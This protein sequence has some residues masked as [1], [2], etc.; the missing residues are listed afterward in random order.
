MRAR[1][2]TYWCWANS[3]LH[4][5]C[6]AE[7]YVDGVSIDVEVRLS[8]EGLTQLFV[9]VYASEGMALLEEVYDTRLEETMT[10]ALAWGVVRARTTA[11]LCSLLV[12]RLWDP[13]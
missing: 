6:H 13:R 10:Q 4:S 9:G 12:C 7:A 1:G 3:S 2:S 5:R 11:A 8:T